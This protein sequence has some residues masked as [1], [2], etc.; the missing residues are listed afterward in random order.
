LA[1]QEFSDYLKSYP[2]TDLAANAYFY[3]AEMDYRAGNYPQAIRGYDQVLQNFPDGNKAASAELKKGFAQIEAG[4][5]DAGVTSLRHVV[6]R[7]P[8]SNEALQ[9]KERLRKLGVTSA[10]RKP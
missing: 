5:K 4:D 10:A 2:N 3:I 9:A 7:F 8:R 6:Q 1:R